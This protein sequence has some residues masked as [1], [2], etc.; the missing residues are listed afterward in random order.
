MYNL[1][2]TSGAWP[3]LRLATVVPGPRYKPPHGRPTISTSDDPAKVQGCLDPIKY[4]VTIQCLVSC[5]CKVGQMPNRLGIT[6]RADCDK[7]GTPQYYPRAEASCL[8]NR[9]NTV[10][11]FIRIAVFIS[12]STSLEYYGE[13]G[14]G[15]LG[16]RIRGYCPTNSNHLRLLSRRMQL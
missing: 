6:I 8:V 1:S 3:Y 10:S 15:P 7:H 2:A 4:R 16:V 5:E 14:C 13:F 9:V 12:S 11:G